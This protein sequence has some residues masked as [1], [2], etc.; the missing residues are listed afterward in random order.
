MVEEAGSE[1][2]YRCFK[3]RSC[4]TCNNHEQIE[5]TSIKEEV[6]QDLINQSVYVDIEN[7]NTIAKLPLL[8]DP[9]VKLHP[10]KNIA[11]KVYNQQLKKLNNH[12][13]DKEQVITSE[14]K[15]QD[16]GH[17][18]FVRNLSID[19][20]NKL[21]NNPIKN[22]IPWRVVWKETSLT[23][24]CRLVFDASQVTSTGF[25]LND[26]IAKGRNNMNKLVEIVLRWCINKVAFHTDIQKM[27][28]SIKLNEEH[29]CLQRYIWQ[30]DLDQTKIPEEKV[31]KT[32][33]YGVKSSG[34]QAEF[35]LRE[36]AK[37]FQEEFPR[38]TDIVS[39]DIYV[40]DC[41]SGENSESKAIK[42]AEDLETVLNRGSF[43]KG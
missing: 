12:P 15:L 8:H 40:D 18:E 27:Y 24:P 34:N 11:L 3:C 23:T 33:I 7:R 17:V 41:I 35:G 32:L 22:F 28:N 31:I 36:T 21:S 1:I 37:L 9:A 20:Q 10:N 43:L 16:L 30:E 6:E 5:L 38:V 26:I 19:M 39:N 29:W 13:E 4:K 2:S 25:S 14:R 42:S